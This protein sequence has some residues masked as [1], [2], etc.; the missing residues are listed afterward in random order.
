MQWN[1][2]PSKPKPKI[3]DKK[4]SFWFA[5][6]PIRVENKWIWFEKYI[7]ISE[8]QLVHYDREEVVDDGIL[9]QTVRNVPDT[10]EMWVVIDRKLIK[11]EA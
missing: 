2:K 10:F 3:G 9:F 7:T 5:V 11:K 6:L 1:I 8:R 4:E